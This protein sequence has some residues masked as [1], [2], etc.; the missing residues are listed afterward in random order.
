M[1]NQESGELIAHVIGSVEDQFIVVGPQ[2]FLEIKNS[3]REQNNDDEEVNFH[4]FYQ[5][6]GQDKEYLY[7][8]DVLEKGDS[9][10][11]ECLLGSTWLVRN[12]DKEL[13]VRYTVNR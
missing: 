12:Q 1:I 5:P 13:L 2:T 10:E 6:P 8:T 11:I 7:D 3:I 4:V 9:I